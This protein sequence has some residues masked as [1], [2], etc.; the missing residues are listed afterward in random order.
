MNVHL[1]QH[2]ETMVKAQV[3]TGRYSSASEV[4][5]EALRL[6][7]DQERLRETK[8]EKLRADVQEAL[9]Q[10]ARGES[11]PFDEATVEDIKRRGRERRA[12]KKKATNNK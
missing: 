11:T 8:L 3:A 2:Q 12:A 5:R 1:T 6:F 7:E 4:I 10:S 9:E